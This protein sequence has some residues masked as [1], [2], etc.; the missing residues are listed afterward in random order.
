[1]KARVVI[2]ARDIRYDLFYITVKYDYIQKGIQVT[3][4]TRICIKK[5]QK[6]DNS[7]SIK[8]GA[9]IFVRYTSS[10]PVLHNCEVSSKYSEPYS[11]YRADT[12]CL[13]TDG[14]QAHCY[15]PEP[16]GWG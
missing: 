8:V 6:G 1:M 5:H 16:F 7:E 15:I 9:L 3:E 2:L 13:R 4:R 11:S 14:L 10:G 12:K